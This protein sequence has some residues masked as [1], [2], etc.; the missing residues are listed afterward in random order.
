MLSLTC[1]TP[2]RAFW[3]FGRSLS[4]AISL[5]HLSC[6][7]VCVLFMLG[8]F[9]GP[10][11]HSH[12]LTHAHPLT[13]THELK[14]CCPFPVYAYSLIE[15]MQRA[16]WWEGR[17]EPVAWADY[18]RQCSNAI[19]MAKCVCIC[20]YFTL[21][22]SL[23]VCVACLLH[24]SQSKDFV[25]DGGKHLGPLWISIK[26]DMQSPHPENQHW[27]ITAISSEAKLR[28]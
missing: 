11:Q 26:K 17:E 25:L 7:V 12:R 2:E 10:A 18:V 4:S 16:N 3:H 6:V 27:L 20:E 14:Q 23:C 24:I 8:L 13:H 1:A 19:A 15:I 22:V 21:S 28:E 9:V 5:S